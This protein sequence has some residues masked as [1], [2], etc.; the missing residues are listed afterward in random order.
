M[1]SQQV[2]VGLIFRGERV[3]WRLSP[4]RA[5]RA[6]RPFDTARGFRSTRRVS[7]TKVYRIPCWRKTRACDFGCRMRLGSAVAR[8][9]CGKTD[10]PKEWVGAHTVEEIT[11]D[12]K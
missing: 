11:G 10:H 12:M 8:G 5:N 3:S 1:A 7:N 6:V 9:T 4:A 2:R